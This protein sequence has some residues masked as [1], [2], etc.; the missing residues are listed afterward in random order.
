MNLKLIFRSTLNENF[1]KPYYSF[2]IEYF[3][4]NSIQQL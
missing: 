4:D 3:K 1:I 2:V